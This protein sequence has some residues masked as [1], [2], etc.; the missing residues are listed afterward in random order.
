[1]L[2]QTQGAGFVAF[3]PAQL[4]A[5]SLNECVEADRTLRC[6]H[7]SWLSQQIYVA[8]V[9]SWSHLTC[10]RVCHTRYSSC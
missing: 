7:S 6:A 1:M 9:V 4:S 5:V 2:R 3:M 10:C 8:R